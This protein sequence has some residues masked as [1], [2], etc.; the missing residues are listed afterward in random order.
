MFNRKTLYLMARSIVSCRFSLKLIKPIHWEWLI[1][2]ITSQ[3]W[4][5][6]ASKAEKRRKPGCY[7]PKFT[8]AGVWEESYE[9]KNGWEKLE[10][11]IEHPKF[12][13]TSVVPRQL[14]RTIDRI[15]ARTMK[16]LNF[17]RLL[18]TKSVFVVRPAPSSRSTRPKFILGAV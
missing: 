10:S 8:L 18:G 11:K 14:H 7:H 5:C 1:L 15:C 12:I 4:F 3:Q 2:D 6:E 17:K 13:F 9:K 16:R